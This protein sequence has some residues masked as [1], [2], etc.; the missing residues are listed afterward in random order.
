MTMQGG[1]K[2]PP[3]ETPLSIRDMG[4]AFGASL[5]VCARRRET[6]EDGLNRSGEAHFS[7]PRLAFALAREECHR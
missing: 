4:G 6:R 3:S 2:L 5:R 1:S 7:A